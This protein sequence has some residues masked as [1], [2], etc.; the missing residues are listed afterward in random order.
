VASLAGCNYNH[1]QGALEFDITGIPDS[2]VG[3]SIVVT[4][5]STATTERDPS[6]GGG[7]Y[8][9]TPL[10]VTFPTIATGAYSV[11]VQAVDIDQTPLAN[12]NVTGT[13]TP[14]TADEPIPSLAI[15]LSATGLQGTYGTPCILTGTGTN[16]CSGTLICKQYTSTDQGI[17]THACQGTTTPCEQ[18]PTGVSCGAFEGVAVNT[19][20]QWE[21]SADGGSCPPNTVCGAAVAASGG[22]RYCQGSL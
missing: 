6:F 19:Y 2:A 18:V 20:C 15:A 10:V 9:S 21:C 3:L 22:K 5:S 14:A 17:C 1:I 8:S 4:D 12:A 7:V 16:S 11:Q 13:F